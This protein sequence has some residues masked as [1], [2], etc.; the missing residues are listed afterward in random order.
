M[1]T[2]TCYSEQ[3]EQEALATKGA[4][5]KEKKDKLKKK[6][7]EKSS[8][9]SSK[10]SSSASPSPRAIEAKK[11]RLERSTAKYFEVR[12]V[13]GEVGELVNGMYERDLEWET[14]RPIYEMVTSLDENGLV[15][16]FSSKGATVA[17]TPD[18]VLKRSWRVYDVDKK[19]Y[20]TEA[21]IEVL[22]RKDKT[23]SRSIPTRA[24]TPH[25]VVGSSSKPVVIKS[26]TP[27][28]KKKNPSSPSKKTT[29]SMPSSTSSTSHHHSKSK[30]DKRHSSS[31]SS[32]SGSRDSHYSSSSS[33]SSSRHSTPTRSPTPY[34]TQMRSSSGSRGA[35]G[36]YGNYIQGEDYRQ[37]PSSTGGG[38]GGGSGSSNPGVMQIQFI[39][40]ILD[41]MYDDEY[42]SLQDW[43]YDVVLL[44]MQPWGV[45]EDEIE[46]QLLQHRDSIE[47]DVIVLCNEYACPPGNP[48]EQRLSEITKQSLPPTDALDVPSVMVATGGGNSA[49]GSIVGTNAIVPSGG[50]SSYASSH[51]LL[52]THGDWMMRGGSGGLDYSGAGGGGYGGGGGRYQQDFYDRRGG[53]SSSVF[54]LRNFAIIAGGAIFVGVSMLLCCNK[55][56]RV[57]FSKKYDEIPLEEGVSKVGI[58]VLALETL[59]QDVVQ[60]EHATAHGCV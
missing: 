21:K 37:Y 9:S 33:S 16:A 24:P 26:T 41:D 6:L 42:Q 51:P 47:S 1:L 15:L 14:D 54:S 12:G 32:S 17:L 43:V 27:R 20:V 23:P 40:P 58:A 59:Q 7:K 3:Q 5:L 2:T 22:P 38:R 8:S 25:P 49:P 55:E 53:S 45:T 50:G 13:K 19:D 46:V 28:K 48:V 31:S 34:P 36:Q 29:K 30:N 44:A 52:D 56:D 39:F 4:A 10:S 60:R 35:R 57:G 11:K 18:R